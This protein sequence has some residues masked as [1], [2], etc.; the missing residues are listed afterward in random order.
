MRFVAPAL[1][2]AL[3]GKGAVD[4]PDGAS[5]RCAEEQR[6]DEVVNPARQQISDQAPASDNR[7]RDRE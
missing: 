1:P 5:D 3:S 2:L 6:V 4:E 7:D